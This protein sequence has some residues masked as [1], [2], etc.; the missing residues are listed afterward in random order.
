MAAKVL[1]KWI[2]IY[3]K[4]KTQKRLMGDDQ[5]NILERRITRNLMQEIS[6]LKSEQREEIDD[7]EDVEEEKEWQ[8]TKKE[9][10]EDS[11]VYDDFVNNNPSIFS[12]IKV[13]P[14]QAS[15]KKSS[16]K[17]KHKRKPSKFKHLIPKSSNSN[18]SFTLHPIGGFFTE[19]KAL[20]GNKKSKH[21]KKKGAFEKQM[22]KTNA[23]G[24]DVRSSMVGEV[25]NDKEESY[26]SYQQIDSKELEFD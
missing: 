17:R 22:L 10:E 15:I 7:L 3:K 16:I 6:E 13:V 11:K 8:P 19:N 4:K 20:K 18:N 21:F 24:W 1:L 9:S 2:Q 5:I 26:Y 12:S 23:L 14:P 25:E